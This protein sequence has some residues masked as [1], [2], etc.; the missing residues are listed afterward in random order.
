[1]KRNSIKVWELSLLLSLCVSL[2]WGVFEQGRQ[3]SLSEKLIRLHVVASGN[4]AGEQELK[5][6]VKDAVVRVLQPL[7]AR[8]ESAGEAGE[9]IQAKR[10]DIL[11]AAQTAA[12][13]E[14]VELVFGR[15]TYTARCAEGYALPAGEYSSLRILIGEAAGHNWWGVIFPQLTPAEMLERSQAVAL[16]DEDEL[17][18]IYER[19]D[20]EISFRVLELIQ[21]LRDWL[22]R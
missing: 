14:S 19:E 5:M 6:Q 13:G 8:A 16:L 9:L 15:E 11:K 2:C 4:S 7:M 21:L 1:M 17:G 3:T 22:G 18:L 20:Y 12:G 10:E